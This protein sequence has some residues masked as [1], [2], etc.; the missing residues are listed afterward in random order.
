MCLGL[1]TS[2]NTE[3]LFSPSHAFRSADI[4]QSSSATPQRNPYR[5]SMNKGVR[6][7]R[8]NDGPANDLNRGRER[9]VSMLIYP[10]LSINSMAIALFSC[11]RM[12]LVTRVLYSI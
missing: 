10:Y 12:D 1:F 6:I 3:Q 9:D 2:A 8:E 5:A 4:D 7:L 11:T